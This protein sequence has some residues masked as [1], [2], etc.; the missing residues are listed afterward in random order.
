MLQ[1]VENTPKKYCVC[2]NSVTPFNGVPEFP[3]LA[4]ISN[5]L[6]LNPSKKLITFRLGNKFPFSRGETNDLLPQDCIII[7]SLSLLIATAGSQY[8]IY[9]AGIRN[10][11][12]AGP[13]SNYL[14]L[15]PSN[16]R[17]TFML[18]NKFPFPSSRKV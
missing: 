7:P 1:K 17:I 18:G 16:I 15:N 5:Y 14:S 13:I 9:V 10:F 4:P 2:L 12:F 3:I 6:S 8:R 11:G